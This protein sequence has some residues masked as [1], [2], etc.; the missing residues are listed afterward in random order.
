[1]NFSSR[2]FAGCKTGNCNFSASIFTGDGWSLRSR[3]LGLSG[4]V[5][6]AATRKSVG[7]A[8]CLSPGRLEACATSDS[9]LAQDNSAVPIKMIRNAVISGF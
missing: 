2:A 8:S 9:R 1:M 3:P 6:T 4:C 5:T 7:Q